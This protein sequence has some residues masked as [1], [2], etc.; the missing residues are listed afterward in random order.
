MEQEVL[1]FKTAEE[2]Q[3]AINDLGDAEDAPPGVPIT[4]EYLAEYDKKLDA[5]LHSEIDPAHEAPAEPPPDPNN[6]ETPA[7]ATPPVVEPPPVETPPDPIELATAPLK[8][9]IDQMR[10]ERSSMVSDFQQKQ[11][12]MLKKIEDIQKAKPPEV[13][14]PPETPVP[15][16]TEA[17][18]DG[19]QKEIEG[20][21]QEMN[22]IGEEEYEKKAELATK[23]A[24][25]TGRLTLLMRKNHREFM[26]K[27]NEELASIKEANKKREDDAKRRQENEKR[28]NQKTT[29]E[30]ARIAETEDF[31]NRHPEFKS[32]KSYKEIEA[33]YATFAYDVATRY[34]NKR[35]DQ[36]KPNEAEIAMAA[37][38][39]GTPSVLEKVKDLTPPD[40]LKTYL[41]LSEIEF[42]QMGCEFDKFRGEWI[43]KKDSRG[44]NIVLPDMDFAFDAVKKRKGITAQELTELTKKT[45]ENVKAAMDRRTDPGE[46]DAPHTPAGM[47]NDMTKEEA[48]KLMQDHDEEKLQLMA[49]QALKSGKPMPKEVEYVNRAFA[50][51]GMDPIVG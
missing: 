35:S 12:E 47:G 25:K 44:N 20:L 37:Y 33:E 51:L 17:E 11:N 1:K 8:S 42:T 36:I 3:V 31:R 9:Q 38:N 18:M 46:I 2:K 39:E 27:N 26:K 48:V 19:V 40:S 50:I 15:S 7:A 4:K 45:A 49:T 41:L 10:T 34:W 21:E 28:E 16:T 43:Q 24:Q 6:P 32:N 5:L 23:H 30:K 29:N 13:Q 22:G 14:T